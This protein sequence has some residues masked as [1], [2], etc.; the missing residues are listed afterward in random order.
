MQTDRRKRASDP[1][2]RFAHVRWLHC[3]GCNGCE[4]HV[5]HARPG[6]RSRHQTCRAC[7]STFGP[8][9]NRRGIAIR[10]AFREAK[11]REFSPRDVA[12]LRDAL[13]HVR[14]ERLPLNR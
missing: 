10:K 14:Q 8:G 2:L 7:G 12:L 9:A 5:V 6:A 1:R 3:P 4:R 11:K 13:T